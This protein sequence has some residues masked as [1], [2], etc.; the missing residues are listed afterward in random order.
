[1]DDSAP[2]AK[3]YDI[4]TYSS[5]GLCSPLSSLEKYPSIT[6][7]VLFTSEKSTCSLLESSIE[8]NDVFGTCSTE[9]YN[10]GNSFPVK[11]TGRQA[12]AVDIRTLSLSS[13][14]GVYT[15]PALDSEEEEAYRYILAL[16]EE[17][18]EDCRPD[19]GFQ[20][21]MNVNEHD[22]TLCICPCREV[23][24]VRSKNENEGNFGNEQ[25]L[26]EPK[27]EAA[28]GENQRVHADHDGFFP[29]LPVEGISGHNI[30]HELLTAGQKTTGADRVEYSTEESSGAAEASQRREDV[31][32]SKVD[33]DIK[34]NL[35]EELESLDHNNGIV[36][37]DV[38]NG[39]HIVE[40]DKSLDW[41]E[42]QMDN[43]ALINDGNGDTDLVECSEE[44]N[45]RENGMCDH[46]NGTLDTEDL[47]SDVTNGKRIVEDDEGLDSG[48]KQM[49]NC[50]LNND[51]SGHTDLVECSE[52]EEEN[53]ME[54]GMCDI[55]RGEG[56]VVEMETRLNHRIEDLGKWECDIL[57]NEIITL[58]NT[59]STR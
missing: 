9:G 8:P 48:E 59:D 40:D 4:N 39:K 51:G 20:L 33:G 28:L 32:S 38:T 57:S 2:Y 34:V 14:E 6:E 31:P 49:D 5:D 42:Q 45:K 10:S 55:L 24:E 12:C 1:M 3:S 15:L 58:M 37:S 43:C 35:S 47:S 46:N 36:P 44:E 13:E 30:C 11:G 21:V 19:S 17:A 41:G 50:A 22:P 27:N 54:S 18:N 23:R 16:D 53:K 7:P 56:E 29:R 26:I 25:T 52:E